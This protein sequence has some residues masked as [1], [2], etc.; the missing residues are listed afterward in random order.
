M[1]LLKNIQAHYK[2][3]LNHILLTLVLDKDTQKMVLG[4]DSEK[5]KYVVQGKPETLN[6]QVIETK[7]GTG[8]VI[9]LH[10][11]D[12]NLFTVS[13]REGI[14]VVGDL[15]NTPQFSYVSVDG[16]QAVPVPIAVQ[17]SVTT[18][19]DIPVN[20]SQGNVF[21]SPKSERKVIIVPGSGTKTSGSKLHPTVLQTTQIEPVT[22]TSGIGAPQVPNIALQTTQSSVTSPQIITGAE[23]TNDVIFELSTSDDKTTQSYEVPLV[24]ISHSQDTPVSIV[25]HGYGSISTTGEVVSSMGGAPLEVAP[26]SSIDTKPMMQMSIPVE[27]AHGEQ[28]L[29]ITSEDGL[30]DA[31]VEL[32]QE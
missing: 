10:A 3:K 16:G 9:E 12:G 24:S 29:L 8:N 11:H 19:Q 6:M 14:Q 5:Q 13:E 22:S 26:S 27:S 7:L 28:V 32:V 15:A 21:K 18:V 4:F 17:Q 25:S 20:S 30:S 1:I 2:L 31:T 23:S